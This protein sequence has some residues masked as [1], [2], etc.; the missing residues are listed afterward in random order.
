MNI[1]NP[2]GS[3]VE[4]SK[5]LNDPARTGPDAPSG[6]V[7]LGEALNGFA[8]PCCRCSMRRGAAAGVEC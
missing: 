7:E 8:R 1:T 2:A 5:P 6:A 4:S 3:T